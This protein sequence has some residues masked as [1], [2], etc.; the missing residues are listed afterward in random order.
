MRCSLVPVV[1]GSLL[2][3]QSQFVLPELLNS[4]RI[5]SGCCNMR[6]YFTIYHEATLSNLLEVVLYRKHACEEAS[7]VMVDLVDYCARKMVLLNI[8]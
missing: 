5:K 7:D 3:D 4:E 8:T 2:P 6:L 1:L